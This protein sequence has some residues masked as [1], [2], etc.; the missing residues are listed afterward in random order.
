MYIEQIPYEAILLVYTYNVAKKRFV[1]CLFVIIL[2]FRA[3]CWLVQDSSA[4]EVV[5]SKPCPIDSDYSFVR[6]WWI[7]EGEIYTFLNCRIIWNATRIFQS[8]IEQVTRYKARMSRQG[9]DNSF[10]PF[11]QQ[12]GLNSNTVRSLSAST[13]YCCRLI[14]NTLSRM[15][16]I[17]KWRQDVR[18][19]HEMMMSQTRS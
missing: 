14:L 10:W 17:E 2:A 4:H 12:L 7:S 16:T 9:I 8:N 3:S 11:T 6:T 19:R 15:K 1:T 13:D 5:A 18:W